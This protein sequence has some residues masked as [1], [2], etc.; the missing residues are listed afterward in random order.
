M[1]ELTPAFCEG[2]EPAQEFPR[3]TARLL[4]GAQI[5]RSGAEMVKRPNP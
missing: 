1:G 2:F 4:R 5:E 3:Y